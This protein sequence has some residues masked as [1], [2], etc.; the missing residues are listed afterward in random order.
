MNPLFSNDLVGLIKFLSIMVGVV[1]L[2]L[3]G[4]VVYFLKRGDSQDRTKMQAELN[5]FGER[6]NKDEQALTRLSEGLMHLNTL[7]SGAQ[8]DTMT[9]IQASAEAQ[10]RA[11]HVV[12]VQVARLQERNDLGECL[13]EFGKSIEQLAISI[14]ERR[15]Q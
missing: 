5:G 1:L 8:R 7:I 15:N 11:V 9:A 6:L 13:A 12:D 2:P 4:L 14:N 10:I 3:G